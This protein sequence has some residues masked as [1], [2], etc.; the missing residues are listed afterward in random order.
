MC[1]RG[2]RFFAFTD[3]L[4]GG[5]KNACPFFINGLNGE[6]MDVLGVIIFGSFG[7][8]QFIRGDNVTGTIFLIMAGVCFLKDKI[9]VIFQNIANSHFQLIEIEI[10]PYWPSL[11]KEY[12]LVD[13]N[14]KMDDI[15][16]KIKDERYN[17]LKDGVKFTL[18]KPDLVYWNDFNVFRSEV[19]FMFKI[20][21]L[22]PA[23]F[24]STFFS[25]QWMSEGFGMYLSG[26]GVEKEKLAII[27]YVELGIY[28]NVKGS[29][30]DQKLTQHGWT[31]G[32]DFHMAELNHKHFKVY[33][34]YV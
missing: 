34:K 28:K 18:L 30:R 20:D 27:P 9:V 29:V 15:W 21:E 4:G 5:L 14:W 7:L 24:K 10:R 19:R 1:V 25:V 6:F 17:L 2:R 32:G 13:D 11:F 23:P 3:K 31:R 16:E 22:N 8:Y 12:N 33:Y 26:P